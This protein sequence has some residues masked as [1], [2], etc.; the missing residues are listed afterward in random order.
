MPGF[1]FGMEC[2][3]K[4]KSV[5]L[6]QQENRIIH[7]DGSTSSDDVVCGFSIRVEKSII[8][9]MTTQTNE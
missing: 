1:V 8:L 2:G 6:F 3:I 7:C 5:S 4:T 9:H